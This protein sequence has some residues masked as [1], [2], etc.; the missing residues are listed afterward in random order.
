MA[1][2]NVRWRNLRERQSKSSDSAQD[3]F[4][5]VEGEKSWDRYLWYE[6]RHEN[7]PT[8]RSS[9]SLVVA[10]TKQ[11]DKA[12]VDDETQ[13]VPTG[14]PAT[15][16]PSMP[17]SSSETEETFEENTEKAMIRHDIP[18]EERNEIGDS[19]FLFGD[20]NNIFA[21]A[22]VPSENTGKTVTTTQIDD[23]T[24]SFD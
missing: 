15:M 20:S 7:G 12:D 1:A 14:Q 5:Q 19:L 23:P 6:E 18:P 17:I 3:Q 8:T 4:A 16:V 21:R 13:S 22:A 10:T 11:T 9:T 2:R 24:V